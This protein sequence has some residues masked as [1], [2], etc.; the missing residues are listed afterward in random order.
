MSNLISNVIHEDTQQPGD[1]M[2]SPISNITNEDTQP[3][4]DA[5][6]NVNTTINEISIPNVT[7]QMRYEATLPEVM[8]MSDGEIENNTKPV[9]KLLLQ[10]SG[11]L[12]AYTENSS[13]FIEN[14]FPVEES[15]KMERRIGACRIAQSLYRVHSKT[16]EGRRKLWAQKEDEAQNLKSTLNKYIRFACKEF[17]LPTA[18]I[19][20]IAGGTGAADLI[21]DLSDMSILAREMKDHLDKVNFD[22]DI[23]D[24]AAALASEMGA[25]HEA[26][27]RDRSE[28]KVIRDK[29]VTLILQSIKKVRRWAHLIFEDDSLELPRFF[30]TIKPKR[31]TTRSAIEDE[32]EV[33]DQSNQPEQLDTVVPNH[34]HESEEVTSIAQ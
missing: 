5:M 26:A 4:G 21:Q 10:A 23:I 34:T 29:M 28:T 31:S 11:M 15:G 16:D 7:D 14:K 1:A 25:L 17:D 22:L 30:D 9:D 19:K 3:Q 13:R 12:L 6:S 2:S 33:D 27:E 18:A 8:A 32:Y 20:K 24:T